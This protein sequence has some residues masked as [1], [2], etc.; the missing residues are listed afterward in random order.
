MSAPSD[1]YPTQPLVPE[2]QYSLAPAVHVAPEAIRIQYSRGGGPGGQNVNKVNTKAEIWI[3]LA[4]IVGLTAGALDRLRVIAG[5]RLTAADELHIVSETHRT[6]EGNRREIFE[7]VREL[8][9]LAKKEPKRRRKTRPSA[10]AKRKRLESKRR[11]GEIK[12][13]R[14]GRDFD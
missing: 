6:Q 10:T 7:R 14:S 5:R 12:Q 8:I 13:R 2:S 4:S 3:R 9:V 1:P 11:R